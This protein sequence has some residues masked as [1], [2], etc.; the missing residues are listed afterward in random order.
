MGRAHDRREGDRRRRG[1]RRSSAWPSPSRARRTCSPSARTATASARRSR[2]S[3]PQNRGGKGIIL[4]DASDRNGPV[5]DIAL[6]KAG[7]EVM[8]ITDHGQTLRTQRRARS[9]RRAATRRACKLM[10]VDDDERVVAIERLAEIAD[11]A[12]RRRAAR[13]PPAPTATLDACRRPPSDARTE[14][15]A[16]RRDAARQRQRRAVAKAALAAPRRSSGSRR[17]TPTRTASSITRT[18]SS[19]SCAT[20]LSRADDRRRSSTRPRPTLFAR[21]PDA[22]A[23][24]KA[25]PDRRRA[26]RRRRSASSARSR[27]TSSGSRSALVE[28]ARRRGAAHARRARRSSR[29]SGARRRT[30]SSASPSNAPEGVVV[31]THVQRISQR[32]G[33]T[34]AHRAREDRAGPDARSSRATTGTTLSHVLIFHGRRICFARKPACDSCAVNDVCP[35]AFKAENV[36][37]KPARS[38][39]EGGRGS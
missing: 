18:R 10:S 20:V 9:A 32:L 4:I 5:V 33:W 27:R 1:R 36:G 6:V 28:R 7:D 35:S 39:E 38:A 8:L 23:L 34:Q 11:G 25:E 3:A 31:D 29:A 30:S 21:Y 37:R 2:S 16:K 24:A 12:S 26:A 14:R 15:G 13:S 17:S 22:R 19:S